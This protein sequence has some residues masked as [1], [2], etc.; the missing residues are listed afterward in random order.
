MG[1]DHPLEDWVRAT[2]PRALGYAR[3]LLGDPVAAEDVVQDCYLRLMQ[4]ADDYNLPR[5]GLK[6]LLRAIWNECRDR[7]IRR[8]LVHNLGEDSSYPAKPLAERKTPDPLQEVVA[9]ELSDR[10]EEALARLP[11]VQR[12]AIVLAAL[13]YSL[14]EVAEVLGTTYANARVLV[15]RARKKLQAELEPFLSEAEDEPRE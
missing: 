1:I 14:P 13:G 2:L 12:A 8:R 10:I 11:M 9:R 4:H 5:D 3:A 15:H 6:I 7:T